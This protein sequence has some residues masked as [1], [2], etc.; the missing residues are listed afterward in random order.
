MAERY[1]ARG[2]ICASQCTVWTQHL[3]LGS[4]AERQS[5]LAAKANCWP[6]RWRSWSQ[7]VLCH[8]PADGVGSRGG[9]EPAHGSATTGTLIKGVGEHVSQKP[10][11]PATSRSGLSAVLVGAVLVDVG[12]QQP[13]VARC[14]RRM[15]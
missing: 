8:E 1:G 4:G 10:R 2:R 15:V 3:G 7:F 14:R 11:P 13:L 9:L 6:W 12:E 5:E